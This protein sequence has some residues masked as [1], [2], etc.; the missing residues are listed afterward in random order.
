[1]RKQGFPHKGELVV[2]RITKIH[3]NSVFAELLEYGK[4][5]MIHVSEVAGR[6][7][8]DI[9]EFLKENQHIVCLVMSTEGDNIMLSVKRVRRDNANRKLSEFKR[10]RKAEKALEL[11]GKA[12]KKNLDA[13]Y[14]EAGFLL[15]EEFGSLHKAFETAVKN[16]GLLKAKG[17]PDKWIKSLTEIAKTKFAEKAY[18][19]RGNL[20]LVCYKPD[21]VEVIKSILMKTEKSGV[22]VK[23][24]SA[25]KYMIIGKG[26]NYKKL[27][28]EIEETGNSIVSFIEKHGGE[29]SF[30]IEE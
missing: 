27:A 3:P 7:V 24:I 9:R 2:C 11:A 12:L 17:V 5:G 29:G 26:K 28:A 20:E 4:P 16:P 8:R 13:S 10:E 21:G 22:E 15:Q 1:M 30:E 23:Y 14:K 19:V 18:I 6:W 25:P